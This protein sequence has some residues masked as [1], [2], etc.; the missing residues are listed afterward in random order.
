MDK[1][2]LGIK[3]EQIEKLIAKADYSAAAK[4]ADTIEWRKVKRWSELI[5]GADLYEKIGRI[6]DARNICIYAYNRNL[7][8]R[9]LV[10]RLSELSII[11][12]DLDEADDLYREFIEMAPHD[13][14]RYVL[15]YKLNKARGV[16]DS[17]LI[18]ILEE[19]KNNE[20]DEQYEYE[21]ASLYAKVGRIEECIRECDDLILWFNEGE[22]VKKAL[23]LKSRHTELTP[24]QSEKYRFLQENESEIPEPDEEYADDQEPVKQETDATEITEPAA[25]ETPV[26]SSQMREIEP[27]EIEDDFEVPEKDYSL[28]DTRN[29]Q[30]ELAKSMEIIM[31]GLRRGDTSV[32]DLPFA[33][34]AV[35]ALG[36]TI[37]IPPVKVEPDEIPVETPDENQVEEN[38]EENAEEV[39]EEVES[40][41]PEQEKNDEYETVIGETAATTEDT[42]VE[43][44]EIRNYSEDEVDEP[45][46][47][48]VINTHRW[49]QVKSEM[50]EDPEAV[51]DELSAEKAAPVREE[52]PEE[53][54]PVQM[55][56]V[57]EEPTV[58]GQINILD[59][60]EH[61]FDEPEP[62]PEPEPAVEINTE[63]DQ[64]IKQIIK[65]ISEDL[66]SR[67]DMEV[68]AA[69][70]LRERDDEKYHQY[71][72]LP[73]DTVGENINEENDIS[74]E[75]ANAVSEVI[76]E[77]EADTE[78]PVEE[79]VAEEYRIP[80]DAEEEYII[81]TSERKYINKYLFM[82]GLEQ[83]VAELL[84][85][86]K[87]EKPDGTSRK[88][89]IVIVGKSDMDKVNFAMNL[90]KSLHAEDNNRELKIAKT[91]AEVLNKKGVQASCEKI[92][93]TTLIIEKAD[94]LNKEILK[95]LSEFMEGDTDSMLVIFTGE[96]F[97]IK[98]IFGENP[99]LAEK[100]DYKLELKHYTINEL[101][102]M[103]KEYARVKGYII[104]DK[105]L[106]KLY[107]FIEEIH[108]DNE[109]TQIDKVKELVDKAINDCGKKPKNLFGK[110]TASMVILKEKHFRR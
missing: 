5:I 6:T 23:E 48:I 9:N 79:L 24:S 89:N 98:R 8:G 107:L 7:G 75:L 30:A 12:N 47:E 32:L 90:F 84:K 96:D 91:S 95:D 77:K 68:M 110:K 87:K 67:V 65:N 51:P 20:L 2:E 10:Y 28:Y 105:A 38:A 88:G 85:G 57:F 81:T 60:L 1:V 104:Q 61:M 17:R 35:A 37:E 72:E 100:F 34:E 103:A 93:G 56:L 76:G 29:I 3:L 42:N 92:K 18:E 22:F 99:Y 86:K 94:K 49:N 109:G 45:T 78:E 39:V 63:E 40:E 13:M 50:E 19:Y 31:A 41:E 54:N 64:V 108:S 73:I 25:Y 33:E 27:E 4:I 69:S 26:G 62:E 11:L 97:G 66:N 44:I 55:E 74:K 101:V 43:V 14:S 80:E 36:D 70:L 52:A 59:Y 46:R 16:S 15:L 71:E 58:E 102:A 82:K 106:L 21:L 53:S 83:S